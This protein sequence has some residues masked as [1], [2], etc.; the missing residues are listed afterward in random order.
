VLRSMDK[1]FFI[2]VWSSRPVSIGRSLNAWMAL[3]RDWTSLQRS[4]SSAAEIVSG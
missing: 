2:A 4:I 1:Y 3:R